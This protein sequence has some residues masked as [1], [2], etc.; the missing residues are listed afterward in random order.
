MEIAEVVEAMEIALVV[1]V[2][3][4]MV[5]VVMVEDLPLMVG[6]M[7]GVVEAEGMV[8]VAAMMI[9]VVATSVSNAGGMMNFTPLAFPVSAV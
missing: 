5:V 4:A 6:Q 3:V 9:A 2:E 7:T 8:E 1:T